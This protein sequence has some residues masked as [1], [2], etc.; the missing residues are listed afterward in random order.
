MS[1]TNIARCDCA[2]C[3]KYR[4][5]SK[6]EGDGK[7]NDPRRLSFG[8]P[9]VRLLDDEMM[10][11]RQIRANLGLPDDEGERGKALRTKAKR[12]APSLGRIQRLSI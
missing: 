12:K 3:V 1:S 9:P 7:S 4:R 2:V 6:G 11:C 10:A 8:E 5:I